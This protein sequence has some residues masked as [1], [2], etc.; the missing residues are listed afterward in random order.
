MNAEILGLLLDFGLLVLIWL[1]QLI[2]YPGFKYVEPQL[3]IFYHRYYTKCISCI[4][5]PLML[6]QV[7]SHV[8][9]NITGPSILRLISI[10]M[11][12]MCWL[13]T[14][15]FSVPCHEKLSKDGKN[16]SVIERL[17]LTNWLRTIAWNSVFLCGLFR[18]F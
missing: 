11:I 5:I 3:F 1:V 17:I 12:A 8:L 14:F 9:K 16:E 7:L 13:V 4:V 2:I 15:C 10:A 18:F 6:G